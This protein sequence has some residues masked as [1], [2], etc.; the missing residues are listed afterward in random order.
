MPVLCAQAP[1]IR[2]VTM[3]QDTIISVRNVTKT[4][5][6]YKS[7]ADRLKETFHPFR[8]KYHDDFNA[9]SNISFDVKKGHNLAI[10]G[11]NGSG[12]STL[13]QII[14][15]IMRPTSG[16][17][18]LTGKVSALLEL[19]AGFNPEFTGE[20]NVYVNAAI[21][22]LS[23]DQTDARFERIA[24]FADIGD[25]IY[26]PVKTYSSGMYVRLAFAVAINV[27]PD[28]LIVDE[29]LAV[30]D[31]YFQHK[32]MR[33]MKELIQNGVTI[34]LVTHDMSAVKSLF[35]E[36]VLLDRGVI[37]KKGES[38]KVVDEY[39]YQMMQEEPG[40][41]I[42]GFGDLRK[43][44]D[45]QSINDKKTPRDMV[46]RKDEEFLKRT[47]DMRSGTGQVRIQN[48]ELLN[49]SEQPITRCSFDDW[50]TVR[51]HMEFF[52]DCEMVNVG[53]HIRDRN[54]IEIIGTNL[55]VERF[56]I[57][58]KKAGDHLIVDFRFRNILRDGNYSVTMAVSESDD[59]GRF[60]TRTFDW[61]DNG[62]VFSTVSKT[63][64]HIHT[65]VYVPVEIN[66]I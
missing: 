47:K 11:R 42:P 9:L 58:P 59:H 62:V 3:K 20:Q 23:R 48:M 43:E 24:A 46:F 64:K 26:Q 39:Y 38:E 33:R 40:H 32:C 63:L 17:V 53:F 10:I 4:Y 28:V 51:G 34:V 2:F 61:V 5:R 52:T 21:L 55:F 15:G 29:A 12:K 1:Y 65:M 30:G 36:A 44:I 14:C 18:E 41:I 66:Y 19:G 50:I 6:L 7:H 13:L 37:I 25:F 35:K 57:P 49:D 16:S 27:D 56:Y 54:G 31:I 45:G 22:G 60:N 8:R